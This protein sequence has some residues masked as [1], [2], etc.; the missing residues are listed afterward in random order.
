MAVTG[1]LTLSGKLRLIGGVKEKM[2]PV[3]MGQLRRAIFPRE[4]EA[5]IEKLGLSE[6]ERAEQVGLAGD[7]EELV[8]A[9]VQGE[10]EQGGQEA[11]GLL[12]RQLGQAKGCSVYCFLFTRLAHTQHYCS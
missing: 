2:R 7:M 6:S 11:F 3:R 12:T 10:G 8:R 1:E 4:N 5:A 9:V